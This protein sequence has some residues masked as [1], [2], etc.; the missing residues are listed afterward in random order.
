MLLCNSIF[1]AAAIDRLLHAARPR[2]TPLNRLGTV[3]LRS[4][5]E[6]RML[7]RARLMRRKQETRPHRAAPY[8][9]I[10]LGG[11]M[12]TV[13]KAL[14]VVSILAV[15]AGPAPAAAPVVGRWG[16]NL[17]KTTGSS[18]PGAQRPA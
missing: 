7:R 14:L 11:R 13:F 5:H 4:L 12:Q 15:T 17:P 1:V 10:L 2:L 8:K 9:S 16:V 6:A 18:R 3:R